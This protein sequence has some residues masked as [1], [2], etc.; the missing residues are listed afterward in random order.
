MSAPPPSSLVPADPER[1][2]CMEVWGGNQAANRHLETPG[3]KIWIYSRP[4]G[5]AVGGGDV[6]Y[7]SSCASGR[8]TRMLL[9]DVSGHG[10]TVS[11]IAVALRDLMRRNV[12]YIRQTRFVRAMNQQFA[13]LDEQGGF[14]TAL[15]S[16]FFAPTGTFSL[17]NAGHPAPLLFDRSEARWSELIALPHDTEVVIDTPL[18][19]VGEARYLQHNVRLQPGDMVLS[20][21]DAVTE[22]EDAE[23]R[24]LGA[25]GVLQ[26]VRDLPV[27]LPVA[28][29]ADVIPALVSR[30]MALSDK[31]LQQDDA[32][33]L[34]CQATGTASSLKDNLLAP[35]RLLGAVTDRTKLA[36]PDSE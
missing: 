17:C 22:S 19:I 29:S 23:G 10:K 20:Y 1:M 34:L 8:I 14:A 24:Q 26:M 32:T 25:E 33:F 21:S 5:G 9:A 16:T 31:N 4:Y 11:H 6:Y 30:I 2:Q 7:V 12:N 36:H 18:G 13:G 27:E 35:F 28:R 15:V 3:L